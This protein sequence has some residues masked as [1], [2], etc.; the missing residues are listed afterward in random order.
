MPK[1]RNGQTCGG[2]ARHFPSSPLQ[3]VP[4]SDTYYSRNKEKIRAYQASPERRAARA[5]YAKTERGK[6]V[7]KLAVKNYDTSEKGAAARERYRRSEKRKKAL[8]R[9]NN[10][11]KGKAARAKY[12]ETD[13]G[14]AARERYLESEKG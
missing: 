10:S 11:E 2:S 5:A 3:E 12:A 8:V 7:H 1:M 14:E 13:K 6:A 9:Y 4:M